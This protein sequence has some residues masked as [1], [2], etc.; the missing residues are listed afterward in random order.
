MSAVSLS[1]ILPVYNKQNSIP[2]V[3]EKLFSTLEVELKLKHYEI[4][5]VDDCS[6]D[7]SYQILKSIESNS[8]KV[9]K[10]NSNL[11]QLNAI[12]TGLKYANGNV[13]SIYSCDIQN[14]FETILPLYNAII[15]GY[16]LAIGYR[17]KRSD[18][19]VNV[20]F[21]KIFFTLISFFDKRIPSGG[22][23]F[24]MFNSRIH[25]ELLS[26]DFNNIFLQM[27]VLDLSKKT[28]YLPIERVI[29]SYDKSSWSFKDRL[30]YALRAFK[31]I[32]K[33]L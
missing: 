12:E 26:K 1:I 27:E 7:R 5:F 31:Y 19:G 3:Y 10:H 20:L 11:G 9:Y 23:D 28:F 14:P 4:I 29:D 24:G 18:T 16:E 17:A 32:F 15:S 2:I 13:I 22:F 30:F 21:S 33:I 8:V 25:R 6:T